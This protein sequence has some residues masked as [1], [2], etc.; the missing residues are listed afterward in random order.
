MYPADSERTWGWEIPEVIGEGVFKGRND[1]IR[2]V[3]G[4]GVETVVVGALFTV[5]GKTYCARLL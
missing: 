1:G 2:N 5:P 3:G 4:G